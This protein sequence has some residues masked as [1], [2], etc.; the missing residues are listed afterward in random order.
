VTRTPHPELEI[1]GGAHPGAVRVLVVDDDEVDREL[2]RR[3]LAKTGLD[4]VVLEDEDPVAALARLRRGGVDVVLLDYQFPKHDGLLVLRGLREQGGVVPVVVLTGHDET[5]LAVDLMKNGAVDYIAKGSL[6]PQRLGHSVRHALRLR[7]SELATRAAQE[8]L[9][10][11]EEFNRRILESSHDCI[12]V[13]DVDGN[14]LMMSPVGLEVLGLSD[15]SQVRG[16]SWLDLWQDEHRAGAEAALATAAAGMGGG[17]VG[18]CP[19][20][21]GTPIWFDVVLSPVLAASGEPERLVATSRDVTDQRRQ[22]EFEQQLIGIVS[23]DLR[24]PLS[25]MMIGASLLAQKLPADSP[26]AE[27]VQRIVGS[28]Q[29]ATRLIRDLLDFT[30]IRAGGRLPVDRRSADIHVVCKQV[31][32]ELALNNPGRLAHR[33]EG[34]GEGQWDPDRLAQVVS[35]LARNALSYGAAGTLVTVRSSGGGDSVQLRIHNQGKPIPAETIPTLFRPFHRGE[36]RYDPE[37]SV[38]LGLFIVREIVHAHG[39][40]VT[41]HSNAVEGTTFV[42]ELPRQ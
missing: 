41:V 31:V 38:G 2:V 42:V 8:A 12:K 16:R 22:A 6:T 28:G 7:A 24:N 32:D 20:R 29:R 26:L 36:R 40:T 1:A 27:I 39:G 18:R 23:H 15:P 5:E 3:L 34:D 13:L 21:D 35:N 19:A 11:S 37:H 17:F 25:A 10:A 33:P 30:Q 4:C 9:R 14:I